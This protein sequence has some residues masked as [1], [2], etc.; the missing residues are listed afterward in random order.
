M[1]AFD[2]QD[3]IDL[4]IK[5]LSSEQC[6]TRMEITR[7][8]EN[9]T[10]IALVQFVA[11]SGFLFRM[12]TAVPFFCVPICQYVTVT[13]DG[14]MKFR[15]DDQWFIPGDILFDTFDEALNYLAALNRDKTREQ[16]LSRALEEIWDTAQSWQG[17]KEA[18]YWNLGD[19]AAAAL[20][21][22][23]QG[24]SRDDC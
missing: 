3:I 19:K 15:K 5:A 22:Y 10:K 24:G 11:D 13:G 17:R 18:P 4:Y 20:M 6:I 1:K 7:Y 9:N 23:N 21:R 14:E 8:I 16:T 2:G 12:E